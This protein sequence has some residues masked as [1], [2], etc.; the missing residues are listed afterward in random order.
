MTRSTDG[1]IKGA[2][3]EALLRALLSEHFAN[4]FCEP[5]RRR[6]AVC[7]NVGLSLDHEC[8]IAR[9]P[10]SCP[11]GRHP[12]FVGRLHTR[13][14]DEED[15]ITVF[16]KGNAVRLIVLIERLDCGSFALSSGHRTSNLRMTWVRSAGTFE[17]FPAGR[18][19]NP[20]RAI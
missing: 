7:R 11:T 19:L 9:L 16:G 5:Q 2:R 15:R 14:Q 3:G 10:P 17:P 8:R 6:L 12:S 18:I 13:R 4:R 20:P 1:G